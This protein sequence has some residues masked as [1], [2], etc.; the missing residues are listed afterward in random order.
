MC[1]SKWLVVKKEIIVI[2]IKKKKRRNN[3]KHV[4]ATLSNKGHQ[5][6][7][8]KKRHELWIV[9]PVQLRNCRSRICNDFPEPFQRNAFDI[10]MV[11]CGQ[12]TMPSHLVW[13]PKLHEEIAVHYYFASQQFHPDR[14]AVCGGRIYDLLYQMS[15]DITFSCC[16]GSLDPN[17]YCVALKPNTIPVCIPSTLFALLKSN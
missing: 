15:P 4:K 6:L 14:L 10:N 17:P 2:S 13:D 7:R 16:S 9:K 12:P 8:D 3:R 5:Q 1:S 11:P